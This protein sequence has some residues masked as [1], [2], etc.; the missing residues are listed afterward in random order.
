MNRIVASILSLL[1]T[2]S[3][4]AAGP[5]LTGFPFTDES[6]SYAINWPGGVGLGEGR[7]IAK[8]ASTGW[9]FELTLKAAVP[10]IDVSDTYAAFASP[11]FCSVSFSKKF[12]HGPRKGGED[13][14]VDRSH[15]TVTRT[16]VPGGGKSDLPVPDC[17]KDAL[18]LLYYTRREMGQ[19]RVPQAQDMLFGGLY[20]AELT[21]AGPET[22]PV[23]GKPTV[24]DKLAVG[25]K[26]PSSETH[27]EI[28]FDRDPARTPVLI[29]VP[30]AM[31]KFS[32]ELVR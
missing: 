31:G 25:L 28:W 20:H 22:V 21:Y 24:T 8:S 4:F 13:E 16:T 30:F 5:A 3:A 27:F 11:D 23:A 6:L 7:M 17:V 19:G 26:G 15:E 10:G 18:T 1:L 9:G 12:I 14:T 29:R 2:A 32:M